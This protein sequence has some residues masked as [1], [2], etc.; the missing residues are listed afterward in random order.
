MIFSRLAGSKGGEKAPLQMIV[1]H[2]LGHIAH[3][4]LLHGAVPDGV[5]GVGGYDDRRD[6]APR[7]DEMLV[8]LEARHPRHLDVGN[9]AVGFRRERR[10]QEIGR[11]RERRD[12]VAQQR[13]ELSHR[14]AKEMVI[15]DDRYQSRFRHHSF[16]ANVLTGGAPDKRLAPVAIGNVGA[17]SR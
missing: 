13:Y 12:G 16:Q 5:I 9:Q 8:K 7:F 17:S 2:R 1:V 15:L 11:R 4:T 6:R 10:F 3:D 14:L